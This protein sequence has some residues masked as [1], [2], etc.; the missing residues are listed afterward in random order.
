[1]K[2]YT[3]KD[4]PHMC[5]KCRSMIDQCV[6]LVTMGPDTDDNEAPLMFAA[7][8]KLLCG[9]GTCEC[10]WSIGFPLLDKEYDVLCPSHGGT[11]E[12]QQAFRERL[13]EQEGHYFPSW[14]AREQ[15]DWVCLICR[16]AYGQA[17]P[18]QPAIEGIFKSF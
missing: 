1:M 14:T 7:D 12:E 9:G 13:C 10:D 8:H 4:Y 5:E 17:Q 15:R 6:E 2:F 18:I 11:E 3:G 16:N